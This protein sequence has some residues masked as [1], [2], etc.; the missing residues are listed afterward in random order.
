MRRFRMRKVVILSVLLM[1]WLALGWAGESRAEVLLRVGMNSADAGQLDPHLTSKTPDVAL[2]QWMFNGLVRFKPGSMDP[3]TIEPDLAEKWTSSPDGKVWTFQLRKGVKF[4]RDYGEL[5]AEDVVFSLQ[6]AMNPKTSAFTS[7]FA[8]VKTIEAVNPYTVKITLTDP[9]PFFLG[10]V[11]NYHAG[12]IVSKKGHRKDG[13]Q[14]HDEPHWNGSIH[15]RGVQGEAVRV[16]RG[17]QAVLSR[18][19]KDRQDHLPIHSLHEQPG[20]RLPERR[21]RPVLRG[22]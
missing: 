5:T 3:R 12:M 10:L 11:S 20:T 21:D 16:M 9:V 15:V 17:Q 14:I 6:R 19:A 13:R 7:D 1:T 18:G 2:L 4:H 8:E 22:S